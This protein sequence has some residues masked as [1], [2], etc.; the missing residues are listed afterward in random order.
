TSSQEGLIKLGRG[1]VDIANS[2]LFADPNDFNL[3][4]LKDHQIAVVVF[5]LVVNKSDALR[6]IINLSIPQIQ[7]IYGGAYDKWEQI[8]PTT[9]DLTLN[10]TI[11]TRP[12]TSGTRAI[13]GQYVL[14]GLDNISGTR[15]ADT[16]EGVASE[17]CRTPGAIGYI[18]LFYYYKYQD[19]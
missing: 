18:S 3:Q 17:V 10:I 15:T 8:D 19:C 6:N 5:A 13:F 4:S 1:K 9:A 14:Q 11:I 2:D 16:S 7:S 12:P